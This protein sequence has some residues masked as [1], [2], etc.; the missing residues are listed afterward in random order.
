MLRQVAAK[1]SHQRE[2]AELV[3]VAVPSASRGVGKFDRIWWIVGSI[4]AVNVS[5][6][7]V[8]IFFGIFNPYLTFWVNFINLIPLTT[9]ILAFT[10]SVS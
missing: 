3:S 5:L 2:P 4:L 1:S 9:C 10:R 6:F 7:V 8:F